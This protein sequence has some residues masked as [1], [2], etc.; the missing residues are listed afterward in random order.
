[1]DLLLFRR[2]EAD[3]L[4]RPDVRED[5]EEAVGKIVPPTS[6]DPDAFWPI[7]WQKP[8][9]A[10]NRI[11]TANRQIEQ[12]TDIMPGRWQSMGESGSE[13]V[14][15]RKASGSR[16]T[17]FDV[18]GVFALKLRSTFRVAPHRLF[19]IQS[20]AGVLRDRVRS[21][22]NNL[23]GDL[24]TMSIE[25]MVVQL[26][27]ELRD[28]WGPITTLH[29]LTDMGLACKPDL[30]VVNS[31]SRLGGPSRPGMV[32]SEREAVAISQFVRDLAEKAYGEVNPAL[33]R[34]VDLLLLHADMNYEVRTENRNTSGSYT[35]RSSS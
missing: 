28:Y 35:S 26:R 5:I 29:L 8:I 27:S 30:H 33:L 24:E 14:V 4:S 34:R 25:D 15:T 23:F 22:R 12:L 7:M 10:N 17:S 20:A 32:P 13:F 16:V 11:S 19:A 3:L 18:S 21:R 9:Y 2:I 31:V 6:S 1:M